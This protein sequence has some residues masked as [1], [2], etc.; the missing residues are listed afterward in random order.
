ML[1]RPPEQITGKPILEIMSSEGFRT[2]HPYVEAVLQGQT[3]EYQ[4]KLIFVVLVL[5]SYESFICRMPMSR[6]A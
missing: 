6:D 2:I 5:A 4:P 1:G 3:V